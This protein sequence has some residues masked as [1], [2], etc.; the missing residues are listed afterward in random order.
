MHKC[1]SISNKTNHVLNG[2]IAGFLKFAHLNIQGGLKHKKDEV[3]RILDKYKPSV[4]GISETNQKRED[5]IDYN[6]TEYNFIPGF[7]YTDNATRVGVL[8]RKGIKYKLRDDIMKNLKLPCVWLEISLNGA[9]PIT[10]INCYR[11]FKLWRS[12][13]AENSATGS[14]QLDD[15]YGKR[16]FADPSVPIAQ[17]ALALPLRQHPC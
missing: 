7:T 17:F 13:D 6:D 15:S 8:I 9:R 11:E 10:V 14:Q 4:F 2:N 3:L 16:V 1:S 5:K 12:E